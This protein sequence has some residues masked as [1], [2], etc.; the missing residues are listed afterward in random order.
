MKR[1]LAALMLLNIFSGHVVKAD[2]LPSGIPAEE[3]AQAIEDFVYVH[4]DTTAGMAVSVFN[5]D[6]VIYEN[7]FGFADREANVPV[8][9]QTVFEWGSAAKIMVW[10]AVMQLHE[11]GLLDFD[12]NILTYLPD[13]YLEDFT[14][15]TEITIMHLFNHEAGFQD[16]ISGLFYPLNTDVDTLKEAVQN[17]QPAQIYEPGTVHGY[18]NWSTALAAVIVEE[19]SGMD[20]PIMPTNIS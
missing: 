17:Q 14:Y 13:A 3:I 7:Y 9:E 1:F 11:Q 20:F 19:I 8:D 18:S 5:S 10:T 2:V 16:F 4:E 6:G 15:D 12:E